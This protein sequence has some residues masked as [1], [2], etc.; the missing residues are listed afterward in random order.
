M[1]NSIIIRE[2]QKLKICLENKFPKIMDFGDEKYQ[3]LKNFY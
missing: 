1:G 3:F 2:L